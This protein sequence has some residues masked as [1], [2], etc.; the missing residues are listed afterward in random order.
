MF[1]VEVYVAAGLFGLV[2]DP[3]GLPVPRVR[4]ELV[5]RD[6]A[7]SVE[8]DTRGR[9][10]IAAASDGCRL[11]I[12]HPGFAPEHQP[13]GRQK[14]WII[15]LRVGDVVE[16]VTVVPEPA[17][18]SPRHEPG[19]LS[20]SDADIRTVAGNTADLVRYASLLEG[21]GTRATAIYVDG[22]PSSV[23]PPIESIGRISVGAGPFSAEHAEG[24]VTLIHIVTKAPARTF[25]FNA[26]SDLLGL[27]GHNVMAPRSHSASRFGHASVR[28]PVPRV[29]ITFSASV[30]LGRTSTDVPIQ[31]VLPGADPQ[32]GTARSAT[33]VRSG[34]LDV[35][36]SLP[37]ALNGRL[38]YRETRA[39]SSNLG[40]GGLVLPEGGFTST[41]STREAR[42]TMAAVWSRMSYEG[43]MAAGQSQ[44]ATLANTDGMGVDVIG[45][46]VRGG[47][48]VRASDANRVQW[49]S[50]HVLRSNSPRPWSAG[51][52]LTTTDLSSRQTP[53][54]AG[55]FQFADI[56]AYESALAGR[57]TGTW[58]V[59]R[60]NGAMQH[61]EITAAPF[62][63]KA[64]VRAD[65]LELDGG[66]RADYQQ[67]FGTIISPRVSMAADWLG[68]EVRAGIGLFVRSVPA[69]VFIAAM[70]NDG[71]HLQ[72]FMA[73]K[74][75]LV[76]AVS[77]PLDRAAAIH[78][79]LASNLTRP[80]QIMGRISVERRLGNLVSTLAYT[81]TDD[82]LLGSERLSEGAGWS[83]VV[84]SNRAGESRRWHMRFGYRWRGQQLVANYE[85]TRARDNS[86]G[87]FSFPE[88]PRRLGSEWARSAGRSPHSFTAAGT[89]GL[90]GAVF[91]NV[92]GSW[93]SF[94]P[95]N[96][97]T[98]VDALGNGLM[99]DRGGR[100]RNSGDGPG[101]RSLAAYGY[102]RVQLP[103]LLGIDRR[104]SIDLG[105]QVDNLLNQR[106]YLSIGSIAGSP[107]FGMPLAAFP[108]R[109]IRFF[110]T[111][112]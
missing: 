80:R 27:G 51:F 92:T 78:T 26:G 59:T 33:R 14:E 40:V 83:D 10:E 24:D 21:A 105:V 98:G 103:K 13:V 49:S 17:V 77:V 107:T 35:Y 94:A 38:S 100:A 34:A 61:T 31:A 2:L 9:F 73:S 53:N 76:D 86:N 45:A 70:A 112:V 46:F 88:D 57:G 71:K 22:L 7:V 42:A 97:T 19:S 23:L 64:L 110:L 99:V 15:R 1:S 75:S 67:G 95:F 74:A 50:K 36:Y 69:D 96:I 56:H 72:Q 8:T 32:A 102:R 48:P 93:R 87:P 90:P 55:T 11:S 28:G 6:H 30:S 5:C 65:R 20:L 63:Q 89:F 82:A 3:H 84:K 79:R 12:R 25:R 52:M 43:G 18:R 106:N 44:S 54:P 62:L 60:G 91:L 16:G 39:E 4:V 104:T 109:S 66:V 111:F 29:P 58:F 68:L 108:G 41:F 101:Y 37:L 81:W 85:W 47:A